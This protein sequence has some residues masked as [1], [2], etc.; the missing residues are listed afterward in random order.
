[1]GKTHPRIEL[2]GRLDS[3]NAA[4]VRVQV[5]AREAG[6]A[7]LEK[8]LEEARE[9]IGEILACE[10]RDVPCSELSLWGLTD[11]EIHLLSAATL[12]TNLCSKPSESSRIW[13]RGKSGGSSAGSSGGGSL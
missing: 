1:M 3:L 8:D 9:K 12:F 13:P 10:V 2:R 6:C 11:E 5:G 4:I 7:E